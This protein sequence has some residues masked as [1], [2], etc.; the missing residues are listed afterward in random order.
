VDGQRQN[1]E[2]RRMD[3]MIK[4]QRAEGLIANY[5]E[6]I[7]FYRNHIKSYHQL[8]GHISERLGEPEPEEP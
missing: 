5:E 6:G 3:I 8:L 4:L 2:I 1:D 7:R